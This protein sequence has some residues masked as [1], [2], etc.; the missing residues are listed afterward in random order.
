M[1]FSPKIGEG[2]GEK[3]VF[4]PWTTVPDRS[5]KQT[6]NVHVQLIGRLTASGYTWSMNSVRVCK[7]IVCLDISGW[8]NLHG[9]YSFLHLKGYNVNIDNMRL[10]SFV[11]L[12]IFLSCYIYI[13]SYYLESG[14]TLT[15][16]KYLRIYVIHHFSWQIGQNCSFFSLSVLYIG[17]W[18]C[19]IVVIDQRT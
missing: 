7:C 17:I 11:M 10:Y 8:S 2:G 6:G 16:L 13:K 1:S 19:L 3:A 18:M 14:S 9:Y 15:R 4:S 12:W 5:G